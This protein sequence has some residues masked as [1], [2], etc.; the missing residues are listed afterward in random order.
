[1]MGAP[2]ASSVTHDGYRFVGGEAGW[3]K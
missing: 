3:V 1:V 2:P